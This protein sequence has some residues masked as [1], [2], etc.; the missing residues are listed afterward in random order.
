[1]LEVEKK[2]LLDIKHINNMLDENK[3]KL[4]VAKKNVEALL[5]VQTKV[6]AYLGYIATRDLAESIKTAEYE[7]KVALKQKDKIEALK[8]KYD[9][10]CELKNLKININQVFDNIDSI[11]EKIDYYKSELEELIDKSKICPTCGQE[12]DQS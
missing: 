5:G 2:L 6:K 10:W 1:M 7:H 3:F 8:A 9:E 11:K 12:W 4:K